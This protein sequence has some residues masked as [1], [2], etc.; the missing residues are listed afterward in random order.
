M[1]ELLEYR[2]SLIDTLVQAAHEFRIECLA[3][4]D[5]LAPLEEN[6]WSV[7]QIAAHTRDIDK[8]VYGSRARRTAV[9][10]DPEFQ[11]FDGDAYMTE[12]YSA[13][14]PLNEILDEL[15][16]NVEGLAQML[17]GLPAEAWSRQSRHVMLG[18]GFTLQAWVER[19]LAHIQEHL[20]TV[21]QRNDG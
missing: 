14:E 2:T 20:E 15:V 10:Y 5:M 1:E 13:S 17:R 16:E 3:V 19:D 4:K 12:R 21:R 7:H 9:E 6:G 18:H 8:L 11:N